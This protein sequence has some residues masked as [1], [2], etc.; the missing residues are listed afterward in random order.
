MGILDGR[1][2][3]IT[4]AGRGIGREEA[5]LFSREG[6]R[7]VVNDLGC[8]RD[9]KGSD[10]SVAEAVVSEILAEGGEAVASGD[11]VSTPDGARASVALAIARFGSIDV[12]VNNAGVL[13]DGAFTRLDDGD[14]E[15]VHAALLGSTVRVCRAAIPAMISQK[16]GGRVVNTLGVAGFTGNLSQSNLAAASAGVFA[17][18]RTLALELKKHEVRVN[19]LCPVARTRYTDDLPMFGEGGLGDETYGPRFVAPAA[20]FLASSLAGDLTGEVLSVAGT[21][22]STWRFTESAGVVG[23]DPRKPWSA[24]EIRGAWTRLSRRVG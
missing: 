16:R 12:V 13:R 18:T 14:F 7:V 1:V 10:P 20:L 6:A 9:G 5:L 2:A 19:A 15:A 4:G 8:G 3:L 17:L 23:D 24:E 21:K 11:D 22:L